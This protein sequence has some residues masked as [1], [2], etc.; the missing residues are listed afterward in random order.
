MT[1]KINNLHDFGERFLRIRSIDDAFIIRG[2]ELTLLIIIN[3]AAYFYLADWSILIILAVSVPV[4]TCIS[5]ILY[6]A[7]IK[8]N[9]QEI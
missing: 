9:Q 5:Y 8:K 6:R 3:S 4:V 7:V 1:G 2:I